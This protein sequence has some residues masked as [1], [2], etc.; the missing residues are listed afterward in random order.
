MHSKFCTLY[1]VL[2]PTPTKPPTDF[3]AT[4]ARAPFDFLLNKSPLQ[5]SENIS[6]ATAVRWKSHSLYA[7]RLEALSLFISLQG[8]FAF[9]PLLLVTLTALGYFFG[10]TSS[11]T[12]R[13]MFTVN[14]N[15]VISFASLIFFQT[16]KWLARFS[17]SIILERI[18]N[19][20]FLSMYS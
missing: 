15:M 20:R 6:D 5:I 16:T 19:H 1:R 17:S 4:H 9:A 2:P 11:R 12:P 10:L 8:T 3:Y 18:Q 14:L 13:K 7:R